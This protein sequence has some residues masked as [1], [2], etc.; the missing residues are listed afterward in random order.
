MGWLNVLAATYD[1]CISEVGKTET[2]QK[3]QGKN[4]FYQTVVLLPVSH[5]T[6]NAGIEITIN[7]NGEFKNAVKVDKNDQMTIMPVSEDSAS[8]S[9][10]ITPMPLFDKL[11]YIAGDYDNYAA[12][13]KKKRPCYEAYMDTLHGW[14]DLSDTPQKVKAICTYLDRGTVLKDLID[15]NIY[16]GTDTFVRFVVIG[17]EEP[18][19]EPWRDKEVYESYI[20]YYD[21]LLTEMDIDYTT[22][23]L[24]PVTQ[25]LPSKI[26]NS[27][28]K[29]KIISSNDTSNYTFRGRFLSASEAVVVGYEVS[30]K[31]HNA[32]RWLIARQGYKNGSEA[33]ICWSPGNY[34]VPSPMND[35]SQFEMDDEEEE[36]EISFDTEELFAKRLNK[37]I[38]GYRQN[39]DRDIQRIEKDTLKVVVMA[40]DTADGS[41]Q[42]RLSITYYNEQEPQHFLNNILKWYSECCW[43]FY[44]RRKQGFLISS[45]SP[46]DIVAAAFGTQR[47]E[48]VD[49]DDK[50]KKKS[51][52][53]LLPC[54]VQERKI[55][56]DIVYAA[57]RNVSNPQRFK[58]ANWDRLLASACAM[59]KK[60]QYDYGKE[61]FS[62]A[63][64][65][66]SMDRDYLFGRLLAAAHKLED[67]VNF[68]SGNSGRET[69]A[70]RYWSTYT[71]KPARTFM[72]IR[73][74]L[75]PYISKLKTGTRN[76]YQSLAEEIFAKLEE[77]NSFHNEPL[78]EN[79]LL[80][81]YSQMAEF[82]NY[83][84]TETNEEEE[85]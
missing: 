22:G 80:G 53:R 37:A 15:K 14:A 33:I 36:D 38:A 77:T 21:T 16:D 12:D 50:I 54:I 4:A 58:K 9:S 59:I 2:I 69:S 55:P 61:V 41:G 68:K 25:K 48:F 35:S 42:G 43:E 71:Q 10:G 30:Q 27:G 63:L 64:N 46:E 56:K 24:C 65:K 8:R 75:Q 28:D 76:Y 32:L 40:V 34:Y 70:M 49:A 52:D 62:V 51:I 79:Y 26:R 84:S 82:R 6:N 57:V 19:L 85:E 73:E 7:E 47:S 17:I 5:I 44:V 31:A 78:K 74:K 29:A 67:Y 72:T 66:E 60:Y 81:Y 23:E 39:F 1:N 13:E 18:V 45:P 11:S 20:R 3:G 83:K